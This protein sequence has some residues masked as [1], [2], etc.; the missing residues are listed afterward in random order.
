MEVGVCVRTGQTAGASAGEGGRP[1][2]RAGQ[3][4]RRACRAVDSCGGRG[5]AAGAARRGTSPRGPAAARGGPSRS[6]S[7]TPR[8]R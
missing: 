1:G 2:C 3:A 7:C 8:R 5:H 6:S 4:A